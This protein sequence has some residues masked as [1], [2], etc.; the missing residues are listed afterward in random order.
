LG[1]NLC[2]AGVLVNKNR[3]III[4]ALGLYIRSDSC[5]LGLSF[6]VRIAICLL[7]ILDAWGVCTSGLQV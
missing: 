4:S 6:T 7:L 5:L 3:A 1:G 2:F